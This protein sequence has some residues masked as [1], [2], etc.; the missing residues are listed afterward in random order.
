[1]RRVVVSGYY[2]FGNAGDEA[3]LAALVGG[4]REHV[5]DARFTVISGNPDRTARL[6]GVDAVARNNPLAVARALAGGD[7]VVSGGGSLLQ[8]VTSQRNIPYYLGVVALARALGKPVMLYAQGVGPVSR[9]LGRRLIPLVCNGV[10]RITVRDQ[11]SL[12]LLRELG[13]VRPPVEVTAD[14]SLALEPAAGFDAQAALRAEG[15]EPGRRPLI[16]MALRSWREGAD[17]AVLVEVADA[18]AAE[19]GA[20]VCF[21]SMQSPD[22]EGMARAVLARMSRPGG[23]LLGSGYH[24]RELLA[25]IGAL[26]LVIG[27]RL[28]ALIFAALAGVPPL[29]LSYDPKIDNFLRALGWEEALAVGNAAA[30]EVLARVRDAL[31][32]REALSRRLAQQVPSLRAR[33]RRNNAIAAELLLAPSFHPSTRQQ[34]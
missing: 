34:D 30:A 3:I 18:L 11:E 23:V 9:R 1:M 5:P 28:H 15:V 26:D 33:A 31:L 12:A 2:G 8:D 16:G 6:H 22:D 19:L 27:M 21:L 25:L 4:L 10:Q 17:P 14:A 24:P 13:V 32:R 7:L 20:Q 29:G